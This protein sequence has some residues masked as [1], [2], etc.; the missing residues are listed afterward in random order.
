MTSSF[1]FLTRS[2]L[3]LRSFPW[4]RAAFFPNKAVFDGTVAEAVLMVDAAPRITEFRQTPT[5]LGVEKA[6]PHPI[7]ANTSV[8]HSKINDRMAGVLSSSYV[9]AP[10]RL[11]FWF[12]S[13]AVQQTFARSLR[14]SLTERL[15]VRHSNM[16]VDEKTIIF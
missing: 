15:A 7:R 5:F 1:F 10:L 2:V 9:I 8:T 13:L 14:S 3:F 11:R 16:W 12:R 6:S 4:A